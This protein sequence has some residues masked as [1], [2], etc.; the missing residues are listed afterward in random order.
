M[1]RSCLTIVLAAGEGT[2][3]RSSIPK[4]LHKVANLPMICH[5]FNN[6]QN[7]KQ[8]NICFILGNQ[9]DIVKETI[10]SFAKDKNI[11]I[12]FCEQKER[13]G[14]AHAV[15]SAES[16]LAK[17]Y[18]DVIICFGDTPLIQTDDLLKA[19]KYLT[20]NCDI[21]V[22]GFNSNNPYGYGRLITKDE[23]LID[24][25]EENEATPEQKL[26]TSCN[27][28][29][30]AINGK[31]ALNL[32]KQIKND[33]SKKEYYLTD[34]IKIANKQNYKAKAIIVD[35]NS[36]LGVNTLAQLN[37]V[38]NIWQNNK[39]KNLLENGIFMQNAESIYFSYDTNIEPGAQLETNIYF[40]VNCEVKTGAY[41]KS[42]CHIEGSKISSKA[43]VGPFARLRPGTILEENSKIGNF[44][45]LKNTKLAKNSKINHLS[46]VGDATIGE[47]SNIGAGVI[48][49]NY[50]GVNKWQTVIEKNV[51]V[52]SNCSLIAP[53][54]IEEGAYIA[55]S[56]II[57]KNVPANAMAIGRA[58]QINKEN[59]A[60]NIK[61]KVKNIKK[62]M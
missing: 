10:K 11:Q 49:C 40:G 42:F 21:V 37:E 30:M 59:Y 48:T 58:Q 3:M 16:E 45:E 33:N 50:D 20:N 57:T 15:L 46:Y 54:N 47:C 39:R 41:I 27:G 9:A 53:L 51:F 52:G 2:R 14:T 6:V 12:A 36:L 56:S 43:E 5:V 38:E 7:L 62:E 29:I 19:R 34:L 60:F 44:C 24:I 35:E 25:V 61:N 18:D 28:G 4:V 23:K 13:L 17:L 31:I 55:S 26:I 1:V 32:L 8:N 22:L